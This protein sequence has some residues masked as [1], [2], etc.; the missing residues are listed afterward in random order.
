MTDVTVVVRKRRSLEVLGDDLELL[1]DDPVHDA[2]GG[3]RGDR[4]TPTA[5]SRRGCPW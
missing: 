4:R 5:P 2:V 3:A 1:L